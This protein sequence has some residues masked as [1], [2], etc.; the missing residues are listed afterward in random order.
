MTVDIK[1]E[2]I[3]GFLHSPDIAKF[4]YSQR[5][6]NLINKFYDYIREHKEVLHGPEC[7][8]CGTKNKIDEFVSDCWWSIDVSKQGI[9]ELIW[10]C[11]DCVDKRYNRKVN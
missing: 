7:V 10:I 4:G 2:T 3:N 11:P 8:A 1:G 9:I 5:E 6:L